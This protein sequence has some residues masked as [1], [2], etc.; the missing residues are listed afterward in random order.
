[1]G[2]HGRVPCVDERHFRGWRNGLLLDGGTYL[3]VQTG[4]PVGPRAGAE[5]ITGEQRRR[6]RCRGGC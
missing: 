6:G 4:E 1:M 3:F 2:L 5:R